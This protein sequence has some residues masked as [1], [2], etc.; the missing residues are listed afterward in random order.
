MQRRMDPGMAVPYAQARP[1]AQSTIP[2]PRDDDTP[3]R[4][5]KTPPRM[6]DRRPRTPVRRSRT[7]V[8]RARVMDNTRES[9]R[10]RSPIRSS[11][12]ESPP[13]DASP[14]N[15]SA[16]LDSEDK[17]KDKSMTD[18]EDEEGA[19]KK[20]SAAQ[21]QL[22][23]QALTTSK[24]SIKVNPAKSRRVSR[25][26]LLDLGDSEVTDR[27]SCLDQPS[28][29]D[30][31]ASTARIA[32][33][34]KEDEEVEKTTLSETLNTSCSTFNTLLLNRSSRENHTCSRS[35]EMPSTYRNLQGTAASAMP[36]R[37][38]PIRCP[39]VCVL[40]RRSWPGGQLSMHLSPTPWWHLSSRNCLPRTRGRSFWGRC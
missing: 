2:T 39:I 7:P 12:S 25:A 15:F 19:Q 31:M 4:R 10:S 16:A 40:I 38:R 24:G 32:Q 28:L 20:V 9:T 35:T 18:D 14:V 30:T 23:R 27:V 17:A 26:S 36:R 11:S 8:R 37:L 6:P 22:F 21:Y 5:S 34:L 1:A 29:K 33:G 3:P 13:R